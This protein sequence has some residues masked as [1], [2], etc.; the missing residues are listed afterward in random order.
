MEEEDC[1]L[2]NYYLNL[3]NYHINFLI[4]PYKTDN[5]STPCVNYLFQCSLFTAMFPQYT[6]L[7]S[8]H[9]GV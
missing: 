1:V 3:Q 5:S 4:L 7:L 6:S 8:I 9:N 2:Y